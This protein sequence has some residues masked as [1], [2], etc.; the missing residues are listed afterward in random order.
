MRLKY[1]VKL[2][3]SF[4]RSPQYTSVSVFRKQRAM[5]AEEPSVYHMKLAADWLLK[6]Q[7]AS[8]DGDGYSRKFSLYAGWDKGYT[9]TTGYIIP[10]L[11]DVASF[12]SDDKYEKSANL[13]ATWL[14]GK[15]LD[16]GAIC[17]IDAGS[18]QV[19]DTGQVLLGFNRM[20]THT[21]RKEYFEAAQKSADWLVAGQEYNG[22]WV[23]D[24]YN[25]RPHSY[26][27]RVA[28]ALL[29]TGVLLGRDDYIDSAERFLTWAA[30]QQNEFGYFAFSEFRPDEYAL[31]HTIIYVLEGFLMAYEV[32]GKQQWLDPVLRGAAALISSYNPEAELLSSQYDFELKPT[33]KEYCITGL[34]QWAGVCVNVYT[35]VGDER[36]LRAAK[37]TLEYL[38][39]IQML[40]KGDIQGALPSSM[41]V[42]GYYGG[43][44]FYNWNSKFFIDAL[45]R[46]FAVTE[47]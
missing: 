18:P 8:T 35:V 9:E 24:S 38:C 1:A 3:L 12:L 45:L 33:N 23:K 41:P 13:A 37:S 4:L 15:Q 11:L 21:E 2:A 10:S 28:A 14:L 22:V 44:E 36:F 7:L 32:T 27:T 26:Y 29:E 17:D 5:V 46:Y 42:W 25:N 43:M 47:K 40:N 30:S 6:S 19:F 20:I 16:S 34:A 39:A 31:L